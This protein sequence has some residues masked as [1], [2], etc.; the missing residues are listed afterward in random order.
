MSKNIFIA[1]SAQHVGKTTSTLGLVAA[2]RSK[3]IDRL[4]YCKPVGQ[5]VRHI[6][7]QLVDKDAFLF[8]RIMDFE[9][10]RE[11]HSPVTLPS[12]ITAKFLDDPSAFTYEENIIKAAKLLDEQYDVVVYEGTGHPGVG[13]VVGLSNAKVAKMVDAQVVMLVEGGIGNTIDRLALCLPIFPNGKST[14]NRSDR[15]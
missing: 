14:Y 15:K 1:A 6:E 2:L 11:I 10:S 5:E 3:G 13:T 12:G 8:S 9:L 4:G 7:N